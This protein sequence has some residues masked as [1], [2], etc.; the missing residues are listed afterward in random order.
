M[1]TEEYQQARKTL[2]F[3][4]PFWIKRLGI[5]IDTHKSFN[6]GR[7]KISESPIVGNHIETLLELH[8]LKKAQ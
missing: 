7:R 8:Q 1:T 6:S 2:G 5:S 3:T 4:V